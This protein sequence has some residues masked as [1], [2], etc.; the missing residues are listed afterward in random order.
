MSH[1]LQDK[2]VIRSG[3]EQTYEPN[4][5]TG[6]Y[7]EAGAE[8]VHWVIATDA[9]LAD[10]IREAVS[11]VSTGGVFVEGNSFSE[12]VK[13]DLF[14]MVAR[15]DRPKIKATARK[16]LERVSAFYVSDNTSSIGRA[17]LQQLFVKLGLENPLQTAP[18]FSLSEKDELAACVRDKNLCVKQ[19]TRVESVASYSPTR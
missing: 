9:Q 11:K 19:Q 10:G 17:K 14:I 7:W 1:L 12:F 18:V 13:P 5:D 15:A 6:R 4:K 2:A 3:R 8:N 16:A